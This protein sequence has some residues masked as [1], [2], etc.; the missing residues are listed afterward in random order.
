M[1]VFDHENSIPC[2]TLQLGQYFSFHLLSL[3]HL[4][5]S[6]LTFAL[7]LQ[8]GY[9]ASIKIPSQQYVAAPTNNQKVIITIFSSLFPSLHLLCL[10][11]HS[12][13]SY[14]TIAF[15][16]KQNN[17]NPQFFFVSL[18]SIFDFDYGVLPHFMI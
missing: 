16:S 2:P 4:L 8:F 6:P 3:S 11:F 15:L 12:T 10:L 9:Q 18:S 17:L 7:V 14:T 1:V 5:H 13:G